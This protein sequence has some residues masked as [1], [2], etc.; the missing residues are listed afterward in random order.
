MF[1]FSLHRLHSLLIAPT[2][3]PFLLLNGSSALDNNP[4]TGTDSSYTVH[5]I[6]FGSFPFSG[7]FRLVSNGP[8]SNGTLRTFGSFNGYSQD[9]FNAEPNYAYVGADSFTY[10]A[11]DSSS[12][13]DGTINLD[14]V[15]NP[16]HAV[17][18]SY[19]VHGILQTGSNALQQNDSDLDS[20]PISVVSVGAASHGSFRYNSYY[21]SFIYEPNYGYIGS[22]SITY[23]LCDNLGLCDSA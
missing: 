19:T 18:D 3:L 15:N 22:D 23:K 20:D 10:H 12:C 16:P 1:T 7:S 8:V 6:L 17:A 21:Q 14:V 2:L 4:P 5:G 11:C 9:S 13:I